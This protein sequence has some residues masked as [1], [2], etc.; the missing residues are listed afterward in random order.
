ME[1]LQEQ[2]LISFQTL[3]RGN[4]I[5]YKIQNWAR[6]NTVLEYNAPRQ[7]DTGF[8]FLPVS[9]VTDLISADRCSEMD[10][11]L[12]LWVSA[13]Y[14]D[15]QVQGSG[16]GPVAYFRNGTGNPLVTYTE[17]SARWGLSRATVGRILKKLATSDYI[18]LMSFPGRHGSVIY[19]QNYLSTM[20]EIS[21]VMVDKEEVA[22]T[23]NIRLEL[24]AEGCADYEDP[25]L[26]HE[27]ISTIA[28]IVTASVALLLMNFSRSGR[29]VDE[30]RAWLKRICITW[31]ILNGLGFIMAYVTPLFAGGQWTG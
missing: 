3:G 22:M 31:A 12:D 14:N 11:V 16:L 24:P 15:N 10:I 20:F 4:V 30:S 8:F 9:I 28:A 26:E 23:L 7:K 5:R 2:H 25:S 29:T 19:L 13:I 27:V 18:S 6:H 21:D 17:L 1:R